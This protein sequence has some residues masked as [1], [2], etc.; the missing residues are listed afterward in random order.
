VKIGIDNDGDAF[1]RTDISIRILDKDALKAVIEQVAAAA[2]ETYAA[3]K[4][5]TDYQ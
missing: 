5:Y 3:M 4:P 1:V 2:E